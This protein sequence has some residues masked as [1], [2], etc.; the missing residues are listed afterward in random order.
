MIE[1]AQLGGRE[2]GQTQRVVAYKNVPLQLG[3]GSYK[4]YSSVSDGVMTM[5]RYVICLTLFLSLLGLVGCAVNDTGPATS[6]SQNYAAALK[7]WKPLAEQG[8]AEAQNNLGAMYFKGWGVSQDDREAVRWFRLSA[9]QGNVEAQFNLGV[10]YD[11]R[12]T[13]YTFGHSAFLGDVVRTRTSVTKDDKEAVHWYR[14]AADQG[15]SKAQFN[16]GMM[17]EYGLGVA[18]DVKEAIRWD[19]LAAEQGNIDAQ[20]RLGHIYFQGLGVPQDCKEAAHWHRLA[21]RQGNYDSQQELN[22]MHQN[23]RDVP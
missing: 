19:R 15:Y 11:S 18:T 20:Y 10:M 7:H 22:M 9:E 6:E 12:L 14:L 23:C 17:Y 5:R 2:L 16:L 8:N 13:F 1:R 4:K 3:D 21:V